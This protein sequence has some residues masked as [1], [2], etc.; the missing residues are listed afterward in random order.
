MPDATPGAETAGTD[1]GS[2]DATAPTKDTEGDGDDAPARRI[3]R[4]WSW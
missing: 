3:S 4:T 2:R 1:D